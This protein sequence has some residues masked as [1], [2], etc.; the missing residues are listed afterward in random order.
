[1]TTADP[2]AVWVMQGWFLYNAASFWQPPQAQA[3]LN[4][5]PVD[6]LLMLDLFA[7]R[8]LFTAIHSYL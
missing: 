2:Y 7:V 1:M 3:L 4:S 5:V 8:L 6:G